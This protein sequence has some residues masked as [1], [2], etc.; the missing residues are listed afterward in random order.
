[1]AYFSLIFTDY[2]TFGKVVKYVQIVYQNV[3]NILLDM[4]VFF[5]K[6]YCILLK[7]FEV[8]SFG[9]IMSFGLRFS[10]N[11]L[12]LWRGQFTVDDFCLLLPWLLVHASRPCL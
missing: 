12:V 7:I 4:S 2:P 5:S 10:S 9:L 6:K 3:D 8:L 1:M 11:A